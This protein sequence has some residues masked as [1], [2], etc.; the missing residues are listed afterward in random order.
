M[1]RLLLATALIFA[2]A[3][4]AA[5][6]LDEARG[7]AARGDYAVAASELQ[8]LAESGDV[9]AQ[10]A[11]GELYRDAKGAS[12]SYE[13]AAAWFRRAAEQ[14]NLDAAYDLA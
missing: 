1:A 4:R 3:A 13:Q 5:A 2:L 9:A 11:L 12:K 14:G 10:L 8:P 7:A 6:G